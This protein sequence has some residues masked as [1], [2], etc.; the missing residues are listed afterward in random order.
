MTAGTSGKLP[1]ASLAAVIGAMTV[2]ATIAGFNAPLF[3]TRL[4]AR[5]VLAT[6]AWAMAQ[7]KA[8]V[9]TPKGNPMKSPGFDRAVVVPR[10]RLHKSAGEAWRPVACAG[11]AVVGFRRQ[12]T[13]G[14]Q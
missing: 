13:G 9:P 10:R 3:S 4:D 6:L 8:Q 1:A 7:M 12:A 11:R 5:S 14:G 2:I